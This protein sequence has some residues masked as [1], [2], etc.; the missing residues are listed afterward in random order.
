M[1]GRCPWAR[2]QA[3]EEGKEMAS[4]SGSK[5]STEERFKSVEEELKRLKQFLQNQDDFLQN[6]D[7]EAG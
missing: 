1:E 2:R 3:G 6:M 7:I 4:S 5:P